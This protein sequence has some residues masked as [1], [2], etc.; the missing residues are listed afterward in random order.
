MLGSRLLSRSGPI[1]PDRA[2]GSVFHYDAALFQTLAYAVRLFI[3]FRLPELCPGIKQ[4]FYEW[5]DSQ[6]AV[7]RLADRN[8][9][10]VP[11]D[12]PKVLQFF[13]DPLGVFRLLQ[14]GLS[15]NKHFDERIGGQV[16]VAVV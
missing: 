12:H 13:T 3:L 2:L 10:S 1:P 8:L 16:A 11:D 9:V 15:I 14:R 6:V 4:K 5:T 7:G